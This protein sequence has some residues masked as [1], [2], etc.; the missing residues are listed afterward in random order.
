[1]RAGA[2]TLKSQI[3]EKTLSMILNQEFPM[4]ELL[5]ESRLTQLFEVS[6]A[7]VREALIELCRDGI[8]QNIPRAGYQII[9]ISEK[10]MRDA[11]ELRLILE[12]EG[13]NLA[14]PRLSPENLNE[15]TDIA[16]KS[17]KV[18]AE[19]TVQDSLNIKMC[20]NNNFHVKLN[21][22]SGNQLMNQ[23]LKE[24]LQLLQRGLAQVMIHEYEVPYPDATFHSGLVKAL[25][26]G[27]LELARENL[28]S[29]IL[30]YER[31]LWR[32]YI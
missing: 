32:N 5:A 25:K 12:L 30:A 14:Y 13:L 26:K 20:L 23:H 19:G 2:Q 22:F 7:P 18:R 21:A 8:L 24:T 31:E 11:F 9:R 4:D 28:K 15:L 17:D 3:Y 16:D 27:D 1:M 29:D 10:K 6:R